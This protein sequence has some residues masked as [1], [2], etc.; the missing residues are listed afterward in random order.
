MFAVLRLHSQ[1]SWVRL[2]LGLLPPEAFANMSAADSMDESISFQNFNFRDK[3]RFE[4]K[5]MFDDKKRF[6]NKENNPPT[7][8]NHRFVFLHSIKIFSRLTENS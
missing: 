6:K 7:N 1:D 3:E 5:D 4:N 8:S 2:Y